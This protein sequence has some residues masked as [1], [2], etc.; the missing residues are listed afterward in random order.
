VHVGLTSVERE[1]NDTN[2]L[3]K[4]GEDGKPL[5]VEVAPDGSEAVVGEYNLDDPAM[6]PPPDPT[7][8]VVA[9]TG[10]DE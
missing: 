4:T 6:L 10:V 3:W 9:R 7:T 1:I 2:K 8:R 5:K